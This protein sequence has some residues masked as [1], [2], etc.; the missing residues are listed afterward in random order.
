MSSPINNKSW[1]LFWDQLAVSVKLTLA[2][3]ILISLA[4]ISLTAFSIQREEQ[5]F[6]AGLE[7]QAEVLLVGLET[8]ASASFDSEFPPALL[9]LT[10]GV[11]GAAN[12]LSVTFF[13]LQGRVIGP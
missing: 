3:S 8:A 2:V 12:V 10:E 13:D 11:E 7:N 9:S 6:R 5:T 4:V 1:Y